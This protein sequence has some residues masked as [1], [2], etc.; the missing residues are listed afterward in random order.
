MYLFFCSICVRLVANL[1]D[2]QYG[3]SLPL[4]LGLTS[5][6]AASETLPI[7][8]PMEPLVRW[9]YAFKVEPSEVQSFEND[10]TEKSGDDVYCLVGGP[11]WESQ[12][13][14][15]KIDGEGAEEPRL[16]VSDWMVD[17]FDIFSAMGDSGD[18]KLKAS[19]RR[20]A[21]CWYPVAMVV[22]FD[23]AD[24]EDIV[25]LSKEDVMAMM[26]GGIGIGGDEDEEFEEYGEDEE[27]G[28][29]RQGTSICA[30]Y[31]I[32]FRS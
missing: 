15:G 8:R 2:F 19:A 22:S 25:H 11:T 7:E 24:D 18:S 30:Y 16:D 6:S 28:D 29:S 3:F 21:A 1:C 32:F 17:L 5:N 10:D 27:E 13:E 9:K 31:N 23:P 12:V 20:L 4:D 14:M 26:L